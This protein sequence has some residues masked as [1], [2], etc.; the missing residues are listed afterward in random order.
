MSHTASSCYIWCLCLASVPYL[1]SCNG[2]NKISVENWEMRRGIRGSKAHLA[3]KLHRVPS[4]SG[5]VQAL[6]DS[7]GTLAR[8]PPLGEQGRE[9]SGMI[10]GKRN[11]AGKG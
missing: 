9:S 1:G 3:S 11:R 7:A 2:S 10:A 6:D 5:A 8:S 4:A